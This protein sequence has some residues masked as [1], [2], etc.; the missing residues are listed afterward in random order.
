MCGNFGEVQQT[1]LQVQ[2]RPSSP[3]TIE[4]T[5]G[6]SRYR[7]TTMPWVRSMS[8]REPCVTRTVEIEPLPP[9]ANSIE[10]GNECNSIRVLEKDF[11]RCGN[12]LSKLRS[13]SLEPTKQSTEHRSD[14][15][16]QDFGT[17]FRLRCTSGFDPRDPW[18][19]CR[20]IEKIR[21][22][23][24]FDLILNQVAYPRDPERDGR[25][26]LPPLN[27][28]APGYP[29]D[30]RS[31]SRERPSGKDAL[32]PEIL[33]LK[34]Q[35]NL[36]RFGGR[37]QLRRGEKP[38]GVPL[39]K[40]SGGDR[41]IFGSRN[42]RWYLGGSKEKSDGFECSRGL[43]RSYASHRGLR[44]PCNMQD[45]Q[46]FVHGTWSLDNSVEI[47]VG[48]SDAKSCGLLQ[49]T[50]PKGLKGRCTYTYGRYETSGE[51]TNGFR[52]WRQRKGSCWLYSG[53]DGR[54]YIGGAEKR[55]QQ[56]QAAR[57]GSDGLTFLR[58]AAVHDGSPPEE[59]GTAW[60]FYSE[61]DGWVADTSISVSVANNA[62][63][64]CSE[65]NE[66]PFYSP[67]DD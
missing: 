50:G 23:N 16:P 60:E 4:T 5:E 8:L 58:S 57:E 42:G 21:A 25:D 52:I 65:L 24:D 29:V 49:V 22:P 39:W 35:Q 7:V 59:I 31:G 11:Q 10:P 47:V 34:S 62:G 2:R 66:L 41:W 27:Q 18:R 51:W 26:R 44:M 54:W 61:D 14:P 3:L 40:Q 13:C 30:P 28:E 53:V 19:T 48:D 17:A 43:I 37:Y 12:N 1:P 33:F 46:V 64:R 20:D 45:W 55:S 67:T 9:R 36:Q 15:G 32:I 6:N 63:E 38:N 56:F